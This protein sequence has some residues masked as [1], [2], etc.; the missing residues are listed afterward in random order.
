MNLEPDMSLPL[1]TAQ[2]G[3]WVGQK[4][5]AADATL[6]IAEMLEICGPVQPDLFVRAL[7]QV[8]HEAETLRVS[9]IEHHGQP[10]QI[11]RSSYHGDFPYLDLSGEANP[12]AVAEAWMMEELSRPVDLANDPLWVSALFKAADDRYYWYQRAH[13]VVYDGYSGGVIARRLAELYTAYVEG[14]EPAPCEFGSLNELIDAESAYRDSDRLRRDRDFWKEKLAD[15]PEAVSLARLGP[16]SSMGGLRRSTG[17]LSIDTVQRLRELGKQT[18][19]SLPQILIAL[20]AAYYHRATG[21]NDL[22]IG[23]PVS[24]R[25]NAAL[26][27]TPGMV[28]NIVAIRLSF[29]PHTTAADLFAQVAQTVRQALRHQQYRYEDL[30]RDLSMIGKGKHIAWLGVNIEPFDYQLQFAG[31]GVISHNVSN[32]SG[33]DLTIFVYDRG[34]G[35][36]LRFDFDANPVLYSVAELDEHR[37]RLALLVDGVLADPQQPLR[38]IDILGSQERERLLHDWNATAAPLMPESLPAL[39]AQ[40]A[41]HTPDAPAL[42]CE[43]ATLTYRQLHERSV[44]QARQLIADGVLPGDI[45]AVMLPRNEQWLIVLLAIMRA[46]ATYLPLD[47]DGPPERIAMMLDDASPIALI[48]PPELCARFGLGGMLLL[49]PEHLDALLDITA[50]EPDLSMPEST[51]YVLYTSGS[52]GQPKGVEVTHRNLGNLLQGMREQLALVASDRFLAIATMVFD[53]AMLERFLPLTSGASVVIASAETVRHPPALLRLMQQHHVTHMWATPSLWRVI[54]A[55]P[56]AQLKQLHALVGGEALSAELA[57]R[58]LQQAT[59][60]TQLYGPTETT[61]LSTAIEL[62]DIGRDAPPIGRPILNTRLYVLDQDQQPVQTGAMGELYIAGAGVAKGYL[63][64]HQLTEARFLSDPFANDGSRMYRTGDLVYWND[65]GLLHFV[66]RADGQVKIRGHRV[67]LGEIECQLARHSAI[68]DAAVAVHREDDGTLVLVGY[69][70]MRQGKS[71]SIDAL[72]SHLARFLPEY[73]IPSHVIVLDAMPLTAT[74]KLDR[75]ALPAPTRSS[76]VAYAEPVTDVEKKLA[77]LWQQVLGVERVGLHDNF[78]QLGGDSLTAAEMVARFP[79]HFGMELPLA[80][81]FEASTIAGLAAYLQRA[82][83]TGDPLAVVLPLRMARHE[84]PLFCIHP[85]IGLSWGYAS[86]LRYLDEQ[87]PVYGLQSRGLRGDASL[88]GSV[89][90]IAADYLVQ[91]RRIQ[92]E[93]PYRMLGWSLGGLIAH[94]ITAQLRAAGQQVEFLALL[95]AYPFVVDSASSNAGEAEEIKAILRFLGFHHHAAE[96]PP[97]HLAALTDLLCKEYGVF[98]MPLVQEITRNDPQLIEHVSAV[99]LNNLLLAR[100][101]APQRIDADVMFFHAAIKEEVDLSDQLYDKPEAWQ[102]YV[103]GWLD[104]REVACHHQTMLDATHAAQIG[105][106]VMQRLHALQSIRVP[107]VSLPV[108]AGATQPS[109]GSVAYA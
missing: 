6:N 41:Q 67:E 66:G 48:A 51:A 65:K 61:V 7:W 49:H 83:T 37:R 54:L 99:T 69:V 40:H 34:D 102:P 44:L 91:M 56:D 94:E 93:G 57:A 20:V 105:K 55:S 104:V 25:I 2:R 97:T 5:G 109:A 85:A 27:R 81:L 72:R 12:R 63:H 77:S 24:G 82:Q 58:L 8:T 11:I 89:A 78:F 92:A 1:T 64:H 3:L 95:D 98:N 29:T 52:T 74:G 16:H 45:V 96:N 14:R 108:V 28:A 73:M 17:H 26:R 33:E 68:A 46:G 13:H 70:V 43:A 50:P 21:A 36:E 62:K 88:P 103:G 38:Q 79:E 87:L 80:S 22:V 84:R 18:A 53:I 42:I 32:G 60:V 90:Q 76:K 106:L 30:R 23:M 86:L 107:A 75:K 35:S 59:R 39:I 100:K 9:V 31:A 15:L 47:P 71:I 101:H 4:I 19:T 10:R